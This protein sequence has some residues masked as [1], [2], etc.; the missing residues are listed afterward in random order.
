MNK[1]NRKRLL[2]ALSILLSSANTGVFIAGQAPV[3]S[4][5]QGTLNQHEINFIEEV[6]RKIDHYVSTLKQ[7]LD[8]F[9]S[10]QN[11]QA[12]EIHVD[13]FLKTLQGMHQE[14]VTPVSQEI[15]KSTASPFYN[16]V[17]TETSMIVNKM[18]D[19]LHTVHGTLNQF[20][21]NKKIGVVAPALMSLTNNIKQKMTG[22][23][24]H[25]E[26]VHHMLKTSHA[27]IANK[28]M[29]FAGH[30]TTMVSKKDNALPTEALSA[31]N[32]RLRCK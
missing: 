27:T 16:A 7:Q 19:V 6:I 10:K 24:P 5:I 23:I 17:I 18:Y 13:G 32:H 12:Y 28:L 22:I 31:L 1:Q 15:H 21:N 2:I 26:K 11:N 8:E 3:I 9:K 25:I 4:Q 29:A 30:I 20:R 14:V